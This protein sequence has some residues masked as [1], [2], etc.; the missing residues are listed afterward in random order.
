VTPGSFTAPLTRWLIILTTSLAC[1]E[2]V[3]RLS[4]VGALRGKEVE[5]DVQSEGPPNVSLGPVPKRMVDRY[6]KSRK[7]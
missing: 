6:G 3:C 5:R 2:V 1:A 4:P 7:K